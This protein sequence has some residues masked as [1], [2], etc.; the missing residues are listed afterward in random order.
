MKA[1]EPKKLRARREAPGTAAA[2]DKPKRSHHK[3]KPAA[4]AIATPAAVAPFDEAAAAT[5]V[6]N[7]KVNGNGQVRELDAAIVAPAAD[8]TT[9]KKDKAEKPTEPSVATKLVRLAEEFY[10]FGLST[11]GE[12][13]ALP[14][15]GP[16]IA[17]L[18]RGGKFSLRAQL[19]RQYRHRHQRHRGVVRV[20]RR[21]GDARR[22][23]A[24]HGAAGTAPA[25]CSSRRRSLSGYG[26][27]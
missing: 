26:G 3:K 18:L 25:G 23:R 1:T 20:G 4:A 7:G 21:Y 11:T 14:K 17:C 19:A 16:R 9:G 24:G 15:H 27:R 2:T 10:T 5:A 6:I 8:T 22:D 12:P 13:F